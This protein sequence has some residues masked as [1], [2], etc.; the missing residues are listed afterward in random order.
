MVTDLLSRPIPLADQLVHH[1]PGQRNHWLI[2]VKD[3]QHLDNQ[4]DELSGLLLGL[5]AVF[6]QVIDYC[7]QIRTWRDISVCKPGHSDGGVIFAHMAVISY[8]LE[9]LVF[10]VLPAD[11]A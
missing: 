5:G 4:V 10:G 2:G 8:W 3:G 11:E 1:L 6:G 9:G 7:S